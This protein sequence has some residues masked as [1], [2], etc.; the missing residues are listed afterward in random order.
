MIFSALGAKSLSTS[1][2]PLAVKRKGQ[3]E[4]LPTT[5]SLWVGAWQALK[6]PEHFTV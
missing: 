4:I 5:S 6:G 2:G 3:A 1:F